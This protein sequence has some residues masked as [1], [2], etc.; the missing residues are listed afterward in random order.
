[1]LRAGECKGL[2][3]IRPSSFL[4]R[5]V[6]VYR[7]RGAGDGAVRRLRLPEGIGLGILLR[8]LTVGLGEGL[9]LAG[10][11]VFF[12]R[13]IGLS[14]AEVGV[15][16]SIG[17]AAS[18]ALQVP[19]GMLADRY[20]GRRV[21]LL[22]VIGSTGVF[23]LYP[24]VRGFG[25]FV[26]VVVAESLCGGLAG[27]A[28]ARYFGDLFAD[29][30]RARGNAWMRST[31]NLGMAIGT[32]LASVPL[33]VDTR[34]AYLWIVWACV[35]CLA[36][37]AAL[38]AVGVPRVVEV[39]RPPPGRVGRRSALADRAFVGAALLNAVF[40]AN[41]P[42]LSVVVPL[43]ILQR[44]DAAPAV[45]SVV[46]LV[47]M[48]IT[49]LFQVRA[50]RGSEDLAGAVRGQRRAAAALAVCCAVFAVTAWTQGAATVVVLVV[51]VVSL[52]VGELYVNAAS[53][54]I[55]YKLAP[56]TRRGE[57]LSV[58]SM[59]GQLS[60]A[61][62]PTVLTFL[63]V[64]HQ[65]VGWAALAVVFLIA[66]VASRRVVDRAARAAQA[67]EGTEDVGDVVRSRPGG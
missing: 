37:E 40:V 26:T 6:L 43:W 57:Y 65:A 7:T 42:L 33:T 51:A 20:G 50:S 48:V 54:G 22:A 3:K 31:R 53:W 29:G 46:L 56:Q 25:E 24:L 41:G 47:N 14:A 59:G 21:W 55:S 64:G 62:G 13:Y 45:I 36:A 44:T 19:S 60:W 18:A 49:V 67:G 11:I 8:S 39:G 10:S 1:V 2:G 28:S 38:V 58:Y 23:G 66:G 16:L 30:D 34:A 4:I 63:A 27:A 52:T 9:F 12:T 61:V 35:A 15:G 17:L 5:S 32:V